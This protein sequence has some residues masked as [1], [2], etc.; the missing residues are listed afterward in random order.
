[1]GGNIRYEEFIK[2]KWN[3]NKVVNLDKENEIFNK[4]FGE[5]IV[6]RPL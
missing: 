6:L 3:W 4:K 2:K 1:M 5:T